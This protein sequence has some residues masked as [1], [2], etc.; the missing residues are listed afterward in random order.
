MDPDTRHDENLAP[1]DTIN[2]S[3]IKVAGIGGLGLV[4]VA[5]VTAIFIPTI[6]VSLTIGAVA[7]VVF[8]VVLI[9]WRRKRGPLPTSGQH[10]GAHE[11]LDFEPGEPSVSG[12]RGEDRAVRQS[13][14]REAPASFL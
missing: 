4:A 8:A 11:L 12:P 9:L 10:P 6:R 2:M 13:D 7:G 14:L 5:V 1:M 3:S